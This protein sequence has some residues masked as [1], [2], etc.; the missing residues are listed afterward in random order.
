[1]GTKRWA[2]V[3]AVAAQGWGEEKNLIYGK[4]ACE[5]GLRSG[6]VLEV[7]APPY[8]PGI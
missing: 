3:Q 5:T 6:S 4:G 2:G 8:R 1:M 7:I